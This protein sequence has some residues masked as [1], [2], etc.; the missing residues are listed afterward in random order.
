MF[1]HQPKLSTG[2]SD[3]IRTN[4]AVTPGT[5]QECCNKPDSTTL[6]F[7]YSSSR[8]RVDTPD[9][10]PIRQCTFPYGCQTISHHIGYTI[11]WLTEPCGPGGVWSPDLDIMSVLLYQLSYKSNFALPEGHDPPT[12][13]LTV[14]RSTNWAKEA[15]LILIQLKL[16]HPIHWSG[17]QS[18][19]LD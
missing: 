3:W 13:K 6:P 1:G 7:V 5:F 12:S 19:R 11:R 15:Y 10:L 4:G 17:W 14:L 2:G 18:P 9:V 16:H 8:G